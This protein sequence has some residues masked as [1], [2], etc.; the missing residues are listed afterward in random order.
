MLR[1]PIARGVT[2][3]S[4]ISR[5]RWCCPRPNAVAAAHGEAPRVCILIGPVRLGDSTD[6]HVAAERHERRTPLNHYQP[7]FQKS[8]RRRVVPAA[9]DLLRCR[10]NSVR[11]IYF[12]RLR[13]IWL[14]IDGMDLFSCP[15]CKAKYAIIRRQAPPD[16]PPACDV[17]PQKFPP[18]EHGDWLTYQRADPLQL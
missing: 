9:V 5:L 18:T 2:E 16:E 10:P 13:P 4:R 14:H 17:C 8:G 15:K 12:L 6:T 11:P 1:R 7:G 3:P